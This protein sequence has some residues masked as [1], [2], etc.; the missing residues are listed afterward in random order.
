MRLTLSYIKN[1]I[2]YCRKMHIHHNYDISS[3]DPDLFI[4]QINP[5]LWNSIINITEGIWNTSMTHEKKL[6]C[7]YSLCV[8]MFCTNMK[9][10]LPLH[11]LLTDIIDSLNGSNELIRILNNFG[12]V[13]S[14][15]T[16]KRYVQHQIET[17][18]K[19]HNIGPSE[20]C[21]YSSFSW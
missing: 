6:S 12:D 11:V 17:A 15:D 1:A 7:I 21:F 3:F 20:K 16:H 4:N 8:L 5:K 2:E 10:S 13:A 19:R 18:R 14:V 9:C